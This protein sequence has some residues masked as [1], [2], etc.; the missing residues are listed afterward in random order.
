MVPYAFALGT[1]PFSLEKSSEKH[2][3]MDTS[4]RFNGA[5]KANPKIVK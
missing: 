4:T 2:F 1:V 3:V 5:H